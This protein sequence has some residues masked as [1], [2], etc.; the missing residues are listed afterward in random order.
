MVS[1]A[2]AHVPTEL[3]TKFPLAVASQVTTSPLYFIV[4]SYCS[5]NSEIVGSHTGYSAVNLIFVIESSSHSAFVGLK[6]RN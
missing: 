4:A 5:E 3:I 2:L 6:T 1:A